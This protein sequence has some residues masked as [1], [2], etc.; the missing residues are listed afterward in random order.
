MV[1][2][3][4]KFISCF[5]GKFEFF[6][7]RFIFCGTRKV[8]AARVPG[9]FFFLAMLFLGTA[10]VLRFGGGVLWV[11]AGRGKGRRR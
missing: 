5:F 4:G 9:V 6:M 2:K 11:E 8:V 1:G 10:E 7:T 3:F